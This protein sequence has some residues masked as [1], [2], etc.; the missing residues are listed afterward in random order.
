MF[1]VNKEELGGGGWS[2]TGIFF[3]FMVG[4]GSYKGISSPTETYQNVQNSN[5][6]AIGL[7]IM[8]SS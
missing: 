5:N 3:F 7:K 6:F 2:D 1:S 4:W 8:Y